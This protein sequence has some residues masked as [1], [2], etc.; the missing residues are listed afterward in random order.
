MINNVTC[1][2]SDP[3]SQ[4]ITCNLND[5]TNKHIIYNPGDLANYSIRVLYPT[6]NAKRCT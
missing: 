3:A 5:P 4:Y 6:V 1:T 2:T